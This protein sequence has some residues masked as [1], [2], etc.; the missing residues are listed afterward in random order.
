MVNPE[1]PLVR[2][3]VNKY[4]VKTFI[5]KGRFN[6]SNWEVWLFL[7]GGQRFCTK[8]LG[9]GQ[10]FCTKILGGVADFARHSTPSN[11][12]KSA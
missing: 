1:R 7:G 10:R 5:S 8:I 9:W 6:N 2:L 4:V 3:H 12:Y 11:L